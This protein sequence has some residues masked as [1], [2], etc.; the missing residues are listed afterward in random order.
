MALATFFYATNK[1]S[2]ALDNFWLSY[3]VHECEWQ[4]KLVPDLDGNGTRVCDEQDRYTG[5]VLVDNNLRGTL[6]PEVS[7]LTSL[8]S[9]DL[10]NNDMEG[11]IPTGETE[12]VDVL[13]L[14]VSCSAHHAMIFPSPHSQQ[15]FPSQSF[16]WCSSSLCHSSLCLSRDWALGQT[17]KPLFG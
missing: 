7:F 3:E 4:T 13:V 17:G 11:E 9:L 1:S 12:C 6:P 14:S 5:L 2:W 8:K 16:F 10:G 15:P